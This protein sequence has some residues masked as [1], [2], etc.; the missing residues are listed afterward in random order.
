MKYFRKPRTIPQ[1]FEQEKTPPGMAEPHSPA[2]FPA[3]SVITKIKAREYDHRVTH[4][5]EDDPKT[6]PIRGK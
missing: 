1:G 4:A 5:V 2:K 3:Q 6:P